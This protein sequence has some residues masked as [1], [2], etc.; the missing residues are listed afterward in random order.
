MEKEKLDKKELE[1]LES[2]AEKTSLIKK[3]IRK[4]IIGQERVIEEILVALLSGG[5]G[6]IVGVPGL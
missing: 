2:L 4:V 6:L 5:H 3:E 1:K